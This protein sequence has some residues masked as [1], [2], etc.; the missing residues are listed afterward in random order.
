M[1]WK[2]I[3]ANS[4]VIILLGVFL[5][6][7][8]WAQLKSLVSNEALIVADASQAVSAANA[9]LQLDALQVERWLSNRAN[10]PSVREP[11]EAGV[12]DA[13]FEAA[14]KQANGLRDAAIQAPALA[15]LHP[16]IVAFV[17][18]NGI[19]LGRNGNKFMRGEDLGK[20][21]PGMKEAIANGRTGSETWYAPQL[22]E[23]W[24]VS[25]APVRNGAGEVLGGIIYG[26][27]LNDERMSRTTDKTSGGAVV[28][29]VE[30]PKGIEMVAKSKS[31]DALAATAIGQGALSESV[32]GAIRLDAAER[33]AG[34]PKDWV[35]VGS[36]LSGYGGARAVLVAVSPASIMD[37]SG[38]LYS[39]FG[40]VVLGLI[41][42]SAA[43]WLLGSYV[44]KPVEE[45]EEGLLQILNGRTD[46]RFE[47]EHAVLGGVVFRINTL[48][49]QLMGVQEDDTDE[50]GRPSL[51]PSTDAFQG[52]LDVD[53]PGA[54][55]AER[56][57]TDAAAALAA[58]P[59]EQY[60]PRLFR[61]YIDAKRSIGD[62]VEH[63][64]QDSFI[65]RIRQRELEMSSKSGR[66]V[67]YQ[68]Q[69]RGR[70]VIL[71]A[72]QLP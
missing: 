6:A 12:R 66:P 29:A 2:I 23:Q 70:E 46:L 72:V 65:E 28:I 42:V 62:P 44:S 19:A 45:L 50:E 51:A 27:P 48:L 54:P 58:E 26:T 11:F 41:L 15:G 4:V 56:V 34:G 18:V 3:T 31:V 16:A 68:V 38:V 43:G 5:S 60:Y 13:R 40:M 52:A 8:L 36:P 39:V 30:G 71:L 24:L 33:L 10:E 1:R 25:F 67:R 22:S 64:T 49:N 21:H 37:V 59:A 61:E 14:T 32:K 57:D 47:I 20:A 35:F 63:I 55:H 9:Q 69:L 17:D 7:L 53:E